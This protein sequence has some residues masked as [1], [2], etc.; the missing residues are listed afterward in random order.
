MIVRLFP[1]IY[2]MEIMKRVLILFFSIVLGFLSVTAQV[3]RQNLSSEQQKP[4]ALKSVQYRLPKTALQIAITAERTTFFPGELS[5]YAASYLD[6]SDVETEQCD[7]WRI[8]S[9]MLTP[10]GIADESKIY[11]IKFDPENS[12]SGFVKLSSDHCLLAINGDLP[13]LPQLIKPATSLLQAADKTGSTYRTPLMLQ[14]GS[15]EEMARAAYRE[16]CDIRR[17]RS[18]LA[19]GEADFMPVDKEQMDVMLRELEREENALLKLFTGTKQI[20][21]HILTTNYVPSRDKTED[22]A[23]RFSRYYGLT[24]KDDV[25]GTPYKIKFECTPDT[26]ANVNN[27]EGV[28][29]CIPAIVK[30]TITHGTKQLLTTTVPMAQFGHTAKLS[31]DYFDNN[32]GTKITYSPVNGGILKIEK[33]EKTTA[34]AS[35]TTPVSPNTNRT[36]I[37]R[38]K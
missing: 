26:L 17:K 22:V 14:A 2:R 4:V 23:F 1:V 24:A 16:I 8:K 21:T 5:E 15:K 3:V 25:S 32:F 29:Y 11:T 18:Y 30:A 7:N 31:N 27:Q 19:K 13:E 33:G 38:R 35:P 20:E 6:L 36:T 34:T 28:V 10:Y 9:L 37:F 12:S